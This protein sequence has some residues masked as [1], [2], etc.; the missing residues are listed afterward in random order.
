MAGV[1]SSG[2][3]SSCRSNSPVNPVLSITLRP[4]SSESLRTSSGMA[5]FPPCIRAPAGPKVRPAEPHRALASGTSPGAAILPPAHSADASAAESTQPP[6]L[7]GGSLSPL[8]AATSAYTGR[9]FVSRCVFNWKRSLKQRLQHEKHLVPVG[10]AIGLGVDLVALG[11]HPSRTT[12]DLE[13]LDPVRIL[14]ENLQRRVGGETA[15]KRAHVHDAA[16]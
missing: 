14:H 15:R 1:V 9:S 3:K 5:I 2:T 4:S 12:H 10:I 11:L 13:G 8:L 6:S 16:G 7:G